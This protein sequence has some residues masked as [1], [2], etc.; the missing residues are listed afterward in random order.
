MTCDYATLLCRRGRT[1]GLGH[2]CDIILS[3]RK[4]MENFQ[5]GIFRD[6]EF[7]V[8]G[9]DT[10]KHHALVAVI[11]KHGGTVVQSVGPS[12]DCRAC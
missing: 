2:A 6:K 11:S 9:F 8:L 4:R 3:Q 7:V 5:Q 10:S 12:V 1:D